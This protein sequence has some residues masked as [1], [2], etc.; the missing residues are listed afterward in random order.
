MRAEYS[1]Y[2]SANILTMDYRTIVIENPTNSQRAKDL[3]ACANDHKA[4]RHFHKSFTDAT[5][6]EQITEVMTVQKIVDKL[7]GGAT[8]IAAVVYGV[9]TKFEID[10][11]Y[12]ASP[13]V[14]SCG[15]CNRYLAKELAQCA[16]P[17]CVAAGAGVVD[18][19]SILVW[20][21]DHTGTLTCRITDEYAAAMLK[22]TATAFKQLPE[23]TI[24]QIAKRYTLQ[25]FAVRV[26]VRLQ[27]VADYTATIVDIS[28][29][30]PA[31]MSANMRTY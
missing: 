1:D 28:P 17:N 21:S 29:Q 25:R 20:A 3:K 18:R 22:Y 19:F 13:V 27:R 31:D 15:K 7:A 10:P 9:L 14:R 12:G 23:A 5:S 4:L 30:D 8:R 26:I 24:D 6:M 11:R 16:D 2:N